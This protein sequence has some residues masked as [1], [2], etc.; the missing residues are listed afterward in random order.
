M[1]PGTWKPSITLS[2]QKEQIVTRIRKAKLLVFLRHHRHEVFTEAFQEELACL[3]RPAERGQP[4]VAPVMLA[5]A[6]I[7]QASTGVII[8]I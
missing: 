4:P 1:R 8:R 3:Y 2:L 7:L 6:L 5:L